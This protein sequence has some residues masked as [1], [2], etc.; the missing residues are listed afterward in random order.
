MF[1]SSLLY[2]TKDWKTTETA[3]CIFYYRDRIN[4][5]QA[6]NYAK[7]VA[8]FDE[9]LKRITILKNAFNRTFYNFSPLKCGLYQK[10]FVPLY[11]KTLALDITVKSRIMKQDYSDLRNKVVFDFT[12]DEKIL[13]EVLS[14]WEFEEYLENPEEAIKESRDFIEMHRVESMVQFAEITKNTKLSKKLKREFGDEYPQ[15][16][17]KTGDK[18]WPN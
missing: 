16:F 11:F 5:E 10:F 4:R 1:S 12:R 7:A 9:E 2:N 18:W 14:E 13:K 6:E 17:W 8:A 15:C 3:N